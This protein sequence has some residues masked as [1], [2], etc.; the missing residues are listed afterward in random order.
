[1]N[2]NDRLD[3]YNIKLKL[4]FGNDCNICKKNK[5]Y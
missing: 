5:K 2:N 1:M 3:I 4:F